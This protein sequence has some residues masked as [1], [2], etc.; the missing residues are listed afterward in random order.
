MKMIKILDCGP[1][2]ESVSKEF[3][4]SPEWIMSSLADY[5]CKFDWIRV[6]SEQK[7]ND[8]H[9]DGWIITGSPRSVY[10]EDDWMLR[11][12]DSIRGV[13][14]KGLP[15]FGICFGH[16]IIAK[17]FGGKV[18]LN[19]KGWELG[20]HTITLTDKGKKS[21]LFKNLPIEMIVYES[22]QDH[23]SILP[24]NAIK[25]AYNDKCIQAF[26]LFDYIFSVQ[27]HPEFSLEIMKK[28]VE[29]RSSSGVMIDDHFVAKSTN[30]DLVLSNFI[31]MI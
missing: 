7:I 23:I 12:E 28:Y 3:G 25:L 5:D 20:S 13:G 31:N 17:S 19:P 14:N 11:L 21:S 24:D 30:S 2:L 29:V 22:H 15:I 6:Y 8:D 1:S 4:Q 10:D 18:E 16:Q 26:Q 27:F 9:A